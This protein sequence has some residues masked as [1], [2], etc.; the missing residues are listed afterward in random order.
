MKE[1]YEEIWK[2]SKKTTSPHLDN[3]GRIFWRRNIYAETQ[4]LSRN[5]VNS[6]VGLKD[7]KWFAYLKNRRKASVA[8][9]W[10][11]GWERRV[12]GW[13]WRQSG[14][15]GSTMKYLGVTL[16]IFWFFFLT[17]NIW[18]PETVRGF[19]LG[20]DVIR[21]IFIKQFSIECEAWT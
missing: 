19:K 6:D 8:G 7:W 15:Q 4:S 12:R 10:R 14:W 21:F 16:S 17:S 5:S 18:D 3:Q 13:R 20:S 1:K 9:A 2:M 11:Q